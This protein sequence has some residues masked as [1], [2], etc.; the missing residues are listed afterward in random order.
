MAVVNDRYCTGSS[1][2]ENRPTAGRT[3]LLGRLAKSRRRDTTQ[4]NG[5]P[6]SPKCRHVSWQEPFSGA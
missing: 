4:V 1:T 2:L 6:P 5:K 3:E